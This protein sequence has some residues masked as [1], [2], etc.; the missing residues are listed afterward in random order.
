MSDGN[1]TATGAYNCT[2]PDGTEAEIIPPHD[3][4]AR[5]EEVNICAPMVRYSKL[6]FR[7]LV[8]QYNCHITTTPMILAKEFSR[9]AIA[10]KSDFSTN[11]H[12]R[13]VFVMRERR[14]S[15]DTNPDDAGIEGISSSLKS[16]ERLVRGALIAQFA[17]SDPVHFAD[18]AELIWPHVDGI[19]LNCGCPQTWAY[20]ERIGSFLLRKPETRTEQLIQTAIQAG[21]SHIGVHGR[22]RQQPSTAPVS[23]PSIAFSVE[24]AKGQVPIVANGDAWSMPEIENIRKTTGVQGVMSARGLLANPGLF[25]G[26][27]RTPLEAV[28]TF[29]HLSTDYGL[30]YGLF[31]RHLMFMLESQFSKSERYIVNQLQS[32]ASVVDYFEGRGLSLYPDTANM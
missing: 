18:A 22:T 19:D 9:S 15:P 7:Q 5:F 30:Q 32:L 20:Q 25:A 16:N 1:P 28:K 8:S 29:V 6:P 17:A 21:V 11:V 10:R 4:L 26:H 31:H 3:M 24:A 14:R 27:E 13:G 2:I 23:L 12:E